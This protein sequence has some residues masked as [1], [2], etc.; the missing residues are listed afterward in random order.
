LAA[1]GFC[2]FSSAIDVTSFLLCPKRLSVAARGYE[3]R[4]R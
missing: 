3:L 1:A 2:F 4:H